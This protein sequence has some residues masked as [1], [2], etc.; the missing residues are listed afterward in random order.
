M[1]GI[2]G[3]F[4]D[5]SASVVKDGRILA[6]VE[7]ER[8]NRKKHTNGIPFGAIDYC[9]KLAQVK[10]EQIDH[11]GYYLDP[12]VMRR[13]LYSDVIERYGAKEEKVRYIA[14]AADR[15]A[16]VKQKLMETYGISGDIDFRYINHHLSHAASAYYIS[17][18]EEAAILT[19]DGSGDKETCVLFKGEGPKIAKVRDILEYPESLGFIYTVLADHLGLGWIEGPGKLMGLAGYGKPDPNFF[20]EVVILR[21]DSSCPVEIDVSYFG[22]HLGEKLPQKSI[23]KFGTPREPGKPFSEAHY[24]L[25]ASTQYMLERSVVHIAKFIPELLPGF[26]NL[27]FAGGVALNVRTNR[28]LMDT[29]LFKSLFVPPPAYDG[30]TSLGCALLLAAEETGQKEFGFEVYCGPNIEADYSVENA[31]ATYA[32]RIRSEQLNEDQIADIASDYVLHDKIIGWA[33][34]R[35]ECGPRALGN[36]SILANPTNPRAKDEL[37]TRVKHREPFRPYSP[38]VLLEECANWFDMEESPYMLMEANVLKEKRGMIP[39]AVHIDGT[40]RVQTVSAEQNRPY[41]KLIRRFFEKTGVPLVINT[42]FNQHGEPM[43]N[44]PEEAIEMLLATEMDALFIGRY[45]IVKAEGTTPSSIGKEA[46]LPQGSVHL[47]PGAKMSMNLD[48]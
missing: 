1:N 18:F 44:R 9:L 30:G 40:S 13:A 37:N 33:Q 47:N 11:I 12:A 38:T 14:D 34:G 43:V 3:I 26:N 16:G 22:Y 21:E 35:M 29:G 39:G 27:C 42:S 17:G 2:D 24:N 48:F 10:L 36:R 32:G 31:L 7:E 41:Y 15:V 5:S 28:S 23:E 25:A 45:H 6:S 4:H 20:D 8:F 19:L 46:Q